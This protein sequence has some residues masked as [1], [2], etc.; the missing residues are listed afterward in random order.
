M[1]DHNNEI[2]QDVVLDFK[3]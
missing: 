3:E 2:D 1:L